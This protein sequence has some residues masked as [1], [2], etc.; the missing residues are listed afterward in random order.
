MDFKIQPSRFLDEK[1]SLTVAPAQK[2]DSV[3]FF[4]S[5]GRAFSKSNHF[6][7]DDLY[8]LDA[9][10]SRKF[11]PKP[12]SNDMIQISGDLKVGREL[13]PSRFLDDKP[14]LTDLPRK[15]AK[16]AANDGQNV[17]RVLAV[18]GV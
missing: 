8:A 9:V 7:G 15:P 11:Q 17:G 13:Q 3:G 1:P 14:L 12:V 2:K 18:A 5:I 4:Q 6:I 10:N 16:I